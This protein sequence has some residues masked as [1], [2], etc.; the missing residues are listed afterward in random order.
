MVMIMAAVVS[1][2]WCWL[3]FSITLSRRVYLLTFRILHTF[4]ANFSFSWINFVS[5]KKFVC[6]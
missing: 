1:S 3:F 2:V 4:V 5:V 6:V